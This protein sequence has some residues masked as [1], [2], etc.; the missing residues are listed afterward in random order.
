MEEDFENFQRLYR[1]LIKENFGN[2]FE[3]D[4]DGLLRIDHNNTAERK[5]LM[6]HLNDNV[7]QNINS[8]YRGMIKYN[9]DGEHLR[10]KKDPLRQNV[11]DEISTD[12]MKNNSA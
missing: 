7:F 2:T 11:K 3:F 6:T 10:T 5:F 9:I 8:K 4:S 12:F 1:P